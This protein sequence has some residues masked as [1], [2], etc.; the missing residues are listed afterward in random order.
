MTQPELWVICVF[1]FIAVF[2]LL[3]LLALAMRV[4][5]AVFPAETTEPDTALLAAVSSAAALAWPG[6]RVTKL[7]EHR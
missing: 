4:L 7:E 1:A 5:T 2:T 6:M 3:S